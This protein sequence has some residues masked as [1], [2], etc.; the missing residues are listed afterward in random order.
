MN[1]TNK[2][3]TFK[4][5]PIAVSGT[6]IKVGDSAPDFKLTGLD[7]QDVTSDNYSGKILVLS[8]VP[9][10][11]TP[12]CSIQTKNFNSEATKLS[13]KITILTVSMDLPFAQKRW[14]GLEEVE[15]IQVA[16][17]YKYR[18]FAMKYGVLLGELGL[19]TRAVFV[20]DQNQK[21]RHVEYVKEVTTEP[22]YNAALQVARQLA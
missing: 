2:N 12:V 9:S 11:D 8:V 7:L 14:C 17:D 21:V 1:T 6:E 20:V 18:D 4:G 19:L 5:N 15:N 22:D 10:L 3:I 16:S 13:D